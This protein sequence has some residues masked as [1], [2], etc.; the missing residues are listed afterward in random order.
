MDTLFSGVDISVVLII[1]IAGAE[2]DT[3]AV[4]CGRFSECDGSSEKSN[5]IYIKKTFKS[6]FYIEN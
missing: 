3:M 6:N 1:D 5:Q 4:Y 2:A